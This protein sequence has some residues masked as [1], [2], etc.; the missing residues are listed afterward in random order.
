MTSL[1]NRPSLFNEM[2]SLPEAVS[3]L[4]ENS[5]LNPDWTGKF[6]RQKL[7][8]AFNVY[9]DGA[10]F[11]LL[12]LLP[13]LDPEKFDLTVKENIL[14]ISGKYSF[15]DWP[16]GL[17]QAV[18]GTDTD[19][20]VKE[21]GPAV[22]TLLKEIPEGQFYRQIQLPSAFDAERIEAHYADGLLKLRL[23]KTQ[24]SQTRRIPVQTGKRPQFM[25][26][27]LVTSSQNK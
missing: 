23:P 19:K 11:Y 24:S 8:T 1:M 27:Q 3:S 5:F 21:T 15:T 2:V 9:E 14:T 7:F 25:E 16:Q 17:T 12:G 6:D 4:F 10:N 20:E 13:G 26:G 22:Q 18:N